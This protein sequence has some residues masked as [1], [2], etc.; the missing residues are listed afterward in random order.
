MSSFALQ[1]FRLPAFQCMPTDPCGVQ[2]HFIFVPG[3]L[4]DFALV[5]GFPAIL[6]A[7]PPSPSLLGINNRFSV[8]MANNIPQNGARQSFIRGKVSHKFQSVKSHTRPPRRGAGCPEWVAGDAGLPTRALAPS[9]SRTSPRRGESGGPDGAQRN[10]GEF[11]NASR[12][13]PR[14]MW[15]ASAPTESS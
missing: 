9:P 14:F 5:G 11:D 10:P 6:P 7:I 2:R 15:A 3:L 4:C 1:Q 13:A 8:S 12:I